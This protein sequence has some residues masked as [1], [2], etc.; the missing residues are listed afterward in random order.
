MI[1]RFP[2]LLEADLFDE[3]QRREVLAELFDFRPYLMASAAMTLVIIQVFF[4]GAHD[5]AVICGLLVALG[6]LLRVLVARFYQGKD[7]I[8]DVDRCA[9]AF[10]VLCVAVALLWGVTGAVLY[11]VADDS[12]RIAVLGIGCV[13]V[14]AVTLRTYMAPGPTMAQVA[15]LIAFHA[16]AI[17]YDG[18]Y[19]LIP[20]CILYTLF[21]GMC[22]LALGRVRVRQMRA[23]R[24]TLRLLDELQ[25][26]NAELTRAN[27]RLADSALSDP[28]TGVGN[29]R[30][31]EEALMTMTPAA[32]RSGRPLS[33]LLVDVDHFKRFN[34]AHGHI[35]GDEALRRVA[36]QL[37]AIAD[38]PDHV[39]ARFGGEEFAVLVAGADEAAA[40]ALAGRILAAIGDPGVERPLTVSIGVATARAASSA[41][42]LVSEA[43]RALYAAKRA[44][45]T[46]VISDSDLGEGD[47]GKGD[48]GSGDRGAGSSGHPQDADRIS[49]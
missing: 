40:R 45:R 39:V 47:L 17:V 20:V 37:R 27:L 36:E 13:L 15:I 38:G 28:L 2:L 10:A 31:F 43:D 29:R 26:T 21:Q 8:G 48:L 44:G 1:D 7:S 19:V 32:M 49:A 12:M 18:H 5:E 24:E 4:S 9:K 33:L 41:V 42:E 3:R 14:Q 35:S 16:T 34:D 23:E 46:R 25:C 30:R 11:R 6:T 22:I